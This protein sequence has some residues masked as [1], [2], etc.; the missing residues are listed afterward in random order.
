MGTVEVWRR[1]GGPGIRDGTESWG[2]GARP[3]DEVVEVLAVVRADDPADPA[4]H[5]W[6][7]LAEAARRRGIEVGAASLSALPYRVVFTAEAV[8]V[9]VG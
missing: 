4:A 2:S 1:P 5:P 8:A 6:A 9:F 3:L 7:E